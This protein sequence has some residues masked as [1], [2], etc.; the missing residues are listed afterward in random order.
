[1]AV[2]ASIYLIS[3]G[4]LIICSFLLIFSFVRLFVFDFKAVIV[5]GCS[6]INDWLCANLATKVAAAC[7]HVVFHLKN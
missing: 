2:F 7:G 4:R 3:F 5:E 6:V 1:V